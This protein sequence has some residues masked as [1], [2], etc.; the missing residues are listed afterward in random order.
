MLHMTHHNCA[1]LL[2]RPCVSMVL[3]LTWLLL[4]GAGAPNSA[5]ISAVV[6]S[7]GV[8]LVRT[9]D[10]GIQPQ[11][12]VDTAGTVHLLYFKGDPAH[13][14]LFY[15]RF[16]NGAATFTPAL[17]V[18]SAPGSVIATGSV[19]GG[20]LALGRGGFVHVAWNASRPIERDGVK[21]TPMW[22]ARL[23]PGGRAFDPQRA[24]GSQTRHL[25]GGGSVAADSVANVYVVWHAAGPTD[26]ELNR[27]IYVA[28]S[29]DD[30][31]RFSKE[32]PFGAGAGLCGCCQLETLIDRRGQ[33]NVLYR[34]AGDNVHR[35]AMWLRLV[36]GSAAAPIRLQ[37]WQLP[38]CPMT[39]FAMTH[40]D[41]GIVAAWETQQQIYSAVLTPES[42]GVSATSAMSG[43]ALR[44]HPSVAVNN[45]GDTLY[46]WTEGTAWA[47]GGTVAWELRDRTG[48]RLASA[49]SA[50]E[51]P[52]WSLVAAV[53]R[54]DG[55]FMLIH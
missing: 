50:G 36:R 40:R 44:K 24:I 18:N 49:S 20:Q 39:T 19:R 30:G 33:L 12:S 28:S 46:A 26:G 38:A 9:P 22:Y 47:R 3:S 27:R 7:G 54:S 4:A 2:D 37:A 34:A 15:S 6:R 5:S 55:S 32:M 35:D 53:T 17:R 23:R 31:G 1:S 52:V 25:D 14:D 10:R 16:P 13:G 48:S 41:P 42:R 8:T 29:S 43:T 21:Q 51:V 45:V 11:A